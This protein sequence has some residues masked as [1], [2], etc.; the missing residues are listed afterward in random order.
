MMRWQR[1]MLRSMRSSVRPSRGSLPSVIM[2]T[3]SREVRI[4]AR[5]L[6]SSWLTVAATSP[7]VARRSWRDSCCCAACS[8]VIMAAKASASVPISSFD[9]FSGGAPSSPRP[10]RI[11]D[12]RRWRSGRMI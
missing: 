3:T 4:A 7:S 8:C 1:P 10:T 2:R 5:G 12:L 9:S 11:A 6:R